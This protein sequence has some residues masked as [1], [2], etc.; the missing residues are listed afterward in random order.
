M[1]GCSSDYILWLSKVYIYFAYTGWLVCVQF[2]MRN[3]T[4]GRNFIFMEF[5]DVQTPAIHSHFE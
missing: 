4:I 1:K 3:L 2:G 5:I